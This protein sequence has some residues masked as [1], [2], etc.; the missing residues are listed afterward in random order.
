[1]VKRSA[2]SWMG[3]FRTTGNRLVS[4]FSTKAWAKPFR[5]AVPLSISSGAEGLLSLGATAV[6]T[7]SLGVDVFG[8]MVFI[9]ALRAVIGALVKVRLRET[10][11]RFGAQANETG[12]RAKLQRLIGFGLVIDVASTLVGLAVLHLVIATILGMLNIPA[13]HADAAYYYGLT[14]AATTLTG[15]TDSLLRLFDRFDLVGIQNVLTPAIRLAGGLGLAFAGAGLAAFLTLWGASLVVSR[16]WLAAVS[17]RELARRDL[18]APRQILTRAALRP[19]AGVWRHSFG[20]F[21]NQVVNRARDKSAPLLIGALLD[22][23]AAAILRIAENIGGLTRKPISKILIPALYPALAQA[24]ASGNH[25][26]RRRMAVRASLGA[27]VL[28]VAIMVP[29]VV[30]GE[31]IL[32]HAFG[33]GFQAAYMPMLLF[34]I[35]GVIRTF[36]SPLPPLLNVAGRVFTAVGIQLVAT[37]VWGTTMWLLVD[38]V[39]V[40]AV[41]LAEIAQTLVTGGMMYAIVR[42]YLPDRVNEPA[43][44]PAPDPAP[45]A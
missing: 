39:D 24:T 21:C 20:M 11:I 38:S 15:T 41:P 44:T 35:A 29:L 23:G 28:G 10:I 40:S 32:R 5:N 43:K 2:S 31:T 37:A 7:R 17:L 9:M 14:V 6:A 1:M 45:E 18:L 12:D 3:T 36:M 33:S 22:P 26:R 42:V 30:F 8:I 27:G 34:A 4:T 16:G 13:T 19:A 25:R